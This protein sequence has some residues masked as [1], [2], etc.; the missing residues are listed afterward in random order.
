LAWKAIVVGVDASL[1]SGDA[2]TMGVRIAQA[3]GVPCWLVH[4]CRLTFDPP[5][6]AEYLSDVERLVEHHVE[7][8]RRQLTSELKSRV[9]ADILAAL[10][11]RLGQS[12]GVVAEVAHERQADLIVVGGKH[13]TALA[14]WAGGSTAHHLV[15]ITDIPLLV[16]GP[17][18]GPIRRV[19]VA[20]DLS[21]ALEPTFEFAQRFAELCRAEVRVLYVA[22]PLPVIAELPVALSD[23]AF[24]ADA[25]DRFHR[26]MEPLHARASFEAVMR[27][28]P[29]SRGVAE[30]AAA[31]NAD[32]VVVG[33][34]G[35]GWIHRLLVGSVTEQL[36]NALPT[37][38]LVVPVPAP[39]HARR[40][41]AASQGAHAAP[42]HQRET[43]S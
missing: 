28:G 39:A 16:V 31:W 25:E 20:V 40:D 7:A 42:G 5:A 32:V 30:E 6:M 38:L 1:A 21:Y 41:R 36:L 13:H 37:S 14:R 23:D 17:R 27:R 2:A 34:H 8:A 26:A 10:D 4:G 22:E 12:A 24:F 11:I 43:V 33:S 19:L 3:A 15:R 35:K 9:P 29:A 18:P